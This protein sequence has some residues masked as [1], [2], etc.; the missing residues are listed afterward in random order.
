MLAH[1]ESADLQRFVNSVKQALPGYRESEEQRHML[2]AVAET[3]DNCLLGSATAETDGSNILV[4]ES[5]TPGRRLPTRFPDW[6]W[7]AGS[8]GSWR[9]PARPSHCTSN[10]Q[11]MRCSSCS[12]MHRGP[13]SG[14]RTVERRAHRVDWHG[15]ST[16]HGSF[17]DAIPA[18][19][20]P[21]APESTPEG[22]RLRLAVAAADDVIRI[23]LERHLVVVP[24][25]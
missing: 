7:G 22:T 15:R 8:A 16:R 11:P 23:T 14:S 25:P 6:F 13:G 4:C 24:H 10:S 5:G 21:Y 2:D 19:R 12:P 20:E 17:R 1:A 18:G 9:S 3:F